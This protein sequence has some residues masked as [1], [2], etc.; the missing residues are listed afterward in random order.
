MPMSLDSTLKPKEF[1]D[2]C[3]L[4]EPHDQECLSKCYVGI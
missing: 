1:T 2:R 4:E 3:L